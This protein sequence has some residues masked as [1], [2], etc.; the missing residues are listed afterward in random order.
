MRIKGKT[1]CLYWRTPFLVAQE[2][3][4]LARRALHRARLPGQ[5]KGPS[6][7]AAYLQVGGDF[8]S[9]FRS[10][11]LFQV[12][13]LFNFQPCKLENAKFGGGVVSKRTYPSDF[14]LSKTLFACTLDTQRRK[15]GHEGVGQ[16]DRE[17]RGKEKYICL[18]GD[19]VAKSA[20]IYS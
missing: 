3:L 4:T 10:S 8:A 2:V 16:R 13:L 17:E 6:D 1:K 18:F 7:A 14:I 20:S 9:V 15:E 11:V 12:L 5:R 19:P